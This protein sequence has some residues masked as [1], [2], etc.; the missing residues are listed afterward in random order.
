MQFNF[1]IEKGHNPD[2]SLRSIFDHDPNNPNETFRGEKEQLAVAIDSVFNELANKMLTEMAY[3]QEDEEE[4]F[5]YL[6]LANKFTLD[7]MEKKKE[8]LKKLRLKRETRSDRKRRLSTQEDNQR[9]Q[10]LIKEDN[11][12]DKKML[13][14]LRVQIRSMK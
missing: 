1:H 3:K 4:R 8:D 9:E 10:K 14:Q 11:A 6:R 2:Q 12:K 13:S 7:A 5:Q